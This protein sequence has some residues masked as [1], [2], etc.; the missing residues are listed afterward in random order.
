MLEILP[1]LLSDQGIVTRIY[2]W[3]GVTFR[4]I[5]SLKYISYIVQQKTPREVIADGGEIKVFSQ[6]RSYLSYGATPR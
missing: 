4:M 1:T 5:I 3:Y 2:P 6:A